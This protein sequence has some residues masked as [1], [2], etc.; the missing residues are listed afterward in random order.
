MLTQVYIKPQLKSVGVKMT[1]K[2][3]RAQ[4]EKVE[5]R[6]LVEER[7]MKEGNRE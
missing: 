7:G 6:I 1:S 2:Q 4:W 3:D 5:K